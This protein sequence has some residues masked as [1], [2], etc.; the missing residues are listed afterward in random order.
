MNIAFYCM[1]SRLSYAAFGLRGTV[2]F[3]STGVKSP[4]PAQSI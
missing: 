2:T 1:F 4:Q 3:P